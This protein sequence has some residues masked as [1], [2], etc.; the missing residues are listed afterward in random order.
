MA[1]GV[2]AQKGFRRTTFSGGGESSLQAARAKAPRHEEWASRSPSPKRRRTRRDVP[3]WNPQS[4]PWHTGHPHTR[5]P[6]DVMGKNARRRRRPVPWLTGTDLSAPGGGAFGPASRRG[7]QRAGRAGRDNSRDGRG[8]GITALAALA[9][10]DGF[11]ALARLAAFDAL[12]ALG[13]GKVVF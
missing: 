11:D 12:A 5:R 8:G 6:Q 10:F 9:A 13:W 2:V 7:P 3:T 1:P 4:G